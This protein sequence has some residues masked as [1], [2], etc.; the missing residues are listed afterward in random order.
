[1]FFELNHLYNHRI[2]EGLC[3]ALA[4]A[5]WFF[6]WPIGSPGWLLGFLL[7]TCRSEY[8]EEMGKKIMEF[9][10]SMSFFESYCEAL[11]QV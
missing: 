9:Y 6:L 4:L 2:K 7:A 1:M 11:P 8:D 10:N 3:D 5:F